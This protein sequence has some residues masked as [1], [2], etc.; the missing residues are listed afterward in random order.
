MEEELNFTPVVFPNQMD[1]FLGETAQD[2][3]AHW[4]WMSEADLILEQ[5]FV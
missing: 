5:E 4:R 1:D 2:H 3:I